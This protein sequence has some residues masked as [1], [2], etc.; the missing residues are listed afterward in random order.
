[1]AKLVKAYD[2][3]SQEWLPL[4]MIKGSKGDKGDTPTITAKAGDHI[5]EVGTPTVSSDNSD[6]NATITFNYLKGQKGDKGD[7]GEV[8][9]QGEQ[10]IQ[11]LTGDTG[12]QGYTFTPSVSSSGELSW[13]NNGGLSNPQTV[14]IKGPKGEQG[15][16]GIQGPKG[17][18]GTMSFED[19]TPTQ[20]ESLKGDTGN[21]GIYY[22]NNPPSDTNQLWVQE[23]TV[24]DNNMYFVQGKGIKRIE[25][26]TNY[27]SNQEADVLYIKYLDV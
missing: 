19:L 22:G 27:P 20:K 16:Q 24:N 8:G 3:E 25:F 5:D 11:G 13:T 2:E 26:V 1:M 18:D 9:P 12:P 4:N 21:D 17:E 10:G 23:T 6:G 14:N 15:I 7:K